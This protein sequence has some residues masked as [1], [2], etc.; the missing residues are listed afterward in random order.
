MRVAAA[1]GGCEL[2]RLRRRSGKL[3]V[4]QHRLGLT[5]WCARLSRSAERR[6]GCVVAGTCVGC[7]G[8]IGDA[9]GPHLDFELPRGCRS[10]TGV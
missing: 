6:G 4:I 10:L 5:G 2:C 1:G 3:V 7:V 9:T 8:A